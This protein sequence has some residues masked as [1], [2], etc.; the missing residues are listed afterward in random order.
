MAITE[1]YVDVVD[2]DDGTGDGLAEVSAYKTLQYALDNTTRNTTDHNFFYIKNG[3]TQTLTGSIGLGTYGKPTL[4]AR[5]NFVGYETTVGDL[6]RVHFNCGGF[7]FYPGTFDDYFCFSN[8]KLTNWGTSWAISLDNDVSVTN[9]E[10][11]GG[12]T[13]NG[14]M[15][16]DQRI[17]IVGNYMHNPGTGTSEAGLKV[18]EDSLVLSNYIVHNYRV[19]YLPTCIASSVM[20][21]VVILDTPTSASSAGIHANGSPSTICN[22]TIIREGGSASGAEGIYSLNDYALRIMNNYVEGFSGAADIA[23]NPS[24]SDCAVYGNNKF[25]NNTTNFDDTTGHILVNIGVD[26]TLGSS[27]VDANYLPTADLQNAGWPSSFATAT[28]TY[29]TVGSVIAEQGG[30]GAAGLMR[31][32]NTNG[33]FQ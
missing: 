20:Y 7:A 5:L 32:P 4:N 15:R 13:S 28:P 25:Y 8:L 33:G 22:N 1:T 2:G 3:A 9:C 30:G 17:A 21:N 18:D 27:G 19:I 12:G 31:Q 11:D 14:Y 6:G 10:L 23:I 16:F 24:T 26:E 29:N